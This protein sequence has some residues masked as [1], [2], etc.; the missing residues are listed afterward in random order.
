MNRPA[1][2]SRSRRS[3]A[4]TVDGR[5]INVV[6]LIDYFEGIGGAERLAVEIALRLDRK[7]FKPAVWTSRPSKGPLVRQLLA[8]DV[9]LFS[10]MRTSPFQLWEWRPFLRYLRSER[11]DIIHA[12]GFGSNV[13]ATLFGRLSGVP[14]IVAHEHTW[15]FEGEPLRRFLDRQLIASWADA[16]LAV[17]RADRRRMFEV[18]GI[19][20]TRTRYV[21]N[22]IPPLPPP[23]EHDV[24]AE[25][26]IPPSA[27]VIGTV[28][29][30]RYQK[31]IDLLLEATVRLIARFPELRVLIAGGGDLA[32]IDL[33]KA[34]A[35]AL[36]L[37]TAVTFLG[38]R[39]DVPDVLAAIDVAVSPSRFEG[40]PL[41]VMEY[42]A[43]E[44]P[45]VATRVGGVPDLIE[46]DVSGVL[47][48]PNDPAALAEGI[49][50]LLED[51]ERARRLAAQARTRQRAEFDIDVMVE[52]IQVLYE[53]LLS[54]R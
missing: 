19:P 36:G 2:P 26:R 24:R 8:S 4:P 50:A 3:P 22:G 30:L 20:Y 44:K 21:P 49:T 10:L 41:A 45:I 35:D 33:L 27:P 9:P 17:S 29:V 52:R 38:L 46:D 37:S 42:M 31:G 15:S 16:F 39:T 14:V 1:L 25:L 13:W 5:P 47:V 53:E 43:A 12:H 7:R 32:D 28:S 6:T 51:R 18:E 23:S 54:A 34:R 40:S 48:E 11:V